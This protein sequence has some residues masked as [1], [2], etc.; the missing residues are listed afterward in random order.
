MKKVTE[1]APPSRLYRSTT[2]RMIAG[3]AGGLG[4]YFNIDPTIIR[5]I[6]ILLTL[7]NGIGLVVYILMWIIVPT[8]N[9]SNSKNTDTIQENLQEM[10]KSAKS[11]GQTLRFNKN[12]GSNNSRFWWAILIIGVGFYF[13]FQ[14]FG[15]FDALEI[16]K[17]WPIILIVLGIIFLMRN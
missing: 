7:F 4:E 5:I 13:L 11:F 6:F 14:N 17:F 10:K 3:V 1:T 2:N 16:D 8:E 15:L 9:Q 12:S